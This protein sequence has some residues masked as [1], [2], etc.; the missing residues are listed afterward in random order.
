MVVRSG[1][2]EGVSGSTFSV[3]AIVKGTGLSFLVTLFAA[4]M[5][6]LAVSITE[7]EGFTGGLDGFTYVSVALGGMLA[8]KQSRNLGWLHGLIVGFI[9][10][11]ISSFLFQSDFS[12][13]QMS[14]G[15][16]LLEAAW[17]CVAGAV[18]GVLGVNI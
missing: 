9:Y 3:A 16:W 18:G 15:P 5:L 6:G 12:I 17:C 1:S 14:T 4:V 2:G 13:A 11:V 8:A 7:W 10:Y